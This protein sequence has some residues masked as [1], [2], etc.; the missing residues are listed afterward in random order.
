M[1]WPRYLDRL[2]VAVGYPIALAV[3]ALVLRSQPAGTRAAWL[4]WA[5]TNAD[6]LGRHP[7][8]S[9]VVSA[10]VAE[11]A[12]VGLAALAAVG[13]ASVGWVLGSWRT[14]LL[15]G[16]AHVLATLA[17]EALLI[18]RTGD[19]Q[20]LDVGPSYVVIAA[21][22][23]GIGYGTWPGRIASALGFA[24]ATPDLFG[25]LAQLELSSVGHVCSVAV[26]VGLGYPLYRRRPNRTVVREPEVSAPG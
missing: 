26:A 24:I 1:G 21:L 2:G 17:S 15:V 10:F 20:V 19:R 4:A 6:N 14:V 22:A 5:S 16:A 7:V 11:S 18:Y 23:A 13:L 3:A 9:L 12:P 25:G 8:G